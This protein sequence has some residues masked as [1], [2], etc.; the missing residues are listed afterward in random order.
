MVRRKILVVDYREE[1]GLLLLRTMKRKFPESLV[2]MS[3]DTTTALRLLAA[4]KFDAVVLH[5]TEN[6]DAATLVKLLRGVDPEPPIVVISGIDRSREVVAVGATEFV[7]FD[8]WLLIGTVV[9]NAINDAR[10]F[11]L[12]LRTPE[13]ALEV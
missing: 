1:S 9:A 11:S 12:S 8:R 13:Q 5:R 10:T 6:D 3:A 4:E 2:Q 7:P